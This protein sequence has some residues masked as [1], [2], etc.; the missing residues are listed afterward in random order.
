MNNK[1]D[2]NLFIYE[3]LEWKLKLNVKVQTLQ[4][5]KNYK[6]LEPKERKELESAKS[7]VECLNN[8]LVKAMKYYQNIP[9]SGM[10]DLEEE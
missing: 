10:I 8:V 9:I 5:K 3:I 1:I 7:N 6:R 4:S 2:T